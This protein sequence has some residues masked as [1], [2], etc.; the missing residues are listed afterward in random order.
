M[1]FPTGVIPFGAIVPGNFTAG[2]TYWVR[3]VAGNTFNFRRRWAA[4]RLSLDR[5]GQPA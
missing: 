3:D 4:R 1:P 2:T 5:Q